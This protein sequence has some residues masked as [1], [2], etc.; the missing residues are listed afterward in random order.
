[1]IRLFDSISEINK[2]FLYETMKI[3]EKHIR[4]IEYIS[5]NS[6]ERPVMEIREKL[7]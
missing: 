7:V 4:H 2:G 5:F 1:M 6:D 3:K